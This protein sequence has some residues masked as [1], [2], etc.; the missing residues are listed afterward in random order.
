V[1]RVNFVRL[2]RLYKKDGEINPWVEMKT[3]FLLTRDANQSVCEFF[4]V[5]R[6]TLVIEAIFCP[7]YLS[8]L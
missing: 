7:R 8:L 4:Q 3:C 1:N 2:F 5:G 6:P